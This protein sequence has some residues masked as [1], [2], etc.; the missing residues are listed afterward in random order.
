MISY[1]LVLFLPNSIVS[2]IKIIFASP[3]K[4][5]K[6]I[7]NN[8]IIAD[9]IILTIENHYRNSLHD[10]WKF[11]SFW[12]HEILTQL[13]VNCIIN[14]SIINF[15]R[16]VI[17]F[18]GSSIIKICDYIR[19]VIITKYSVVINI[20]ATTSFLDSFNNFIKHFASYLPILISD[21]YFCL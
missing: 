1:S 20:N 9:H 17:S 4:F 11:I 8:C 5:I 13:L 19:K 3:L 15:L 12:C 16:N 10:K 6:S 18:L 7:C 2:I 21:S 14:F